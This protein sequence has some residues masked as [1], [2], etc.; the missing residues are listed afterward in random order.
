MAQIKRNLQDKFSQKGVRLLAGR[1]ALS[2]A[3]KA[4][5]FASSES[6][7][8][9]TRRARGRGSSSSL[10]LLF[11]RRRSR[12]PLLVRRGFGGTPSPLLFFFPLDGWFFLEK[13]FLRGCFFFREKISGGFFLTAPC[14]FFFE[15]IS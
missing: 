4:A 11:E 14:R 3:G 12:Q 8:R 7:S 15:K 9:E 13:F 1:L 2:A 6:R 5:A 10:L